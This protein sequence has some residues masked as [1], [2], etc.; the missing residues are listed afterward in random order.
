MRHDDLWLTASD[1]APLF[2]NRWRG[3]QPPKAVLMLAH[4]MA[5]HSGRYARLAEHLVQAGYALYAHDQRGHGKTAQRGVLGLYA[6][7]GGWQRVVNDLVNLNQHIRQQH[8]DTPI[9]LIGH[10]MGSYIGQAY[11]IQHSA[12]VQGAI[13]SGS[14]YQPVGLYK[15]AANIARFERWRQGPTGR[16]ALL[17]FLSFG[18]FNKAFKP[19]RTPFDWLSRDP[20]E[21]DKYVSDPLCGFRCTNQLWID[22]LEGLQQITPSTNLG[23]IAHDLP[24][25]VVG[26]ERDPVSQ[27]QRLNDL[28][29]ALQAGGLRHVELKVYA[30]ARHELLNETNRDEVTAFFIDWLERTLAETPVAPA[31]ALA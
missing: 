16:S 26:G 28:A 7:H 9:F 5:E 1:A 21:V 10:S 4:G 31:Q 12:D 11:L 3:E 23:Q 2:V 15:L 13:L 17:E 14:N 25:L 8:P 6:E 30:D 20:V 19:N 27:G 29:A 24:V 18:S 22:L